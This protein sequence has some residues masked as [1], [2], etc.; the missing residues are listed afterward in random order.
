[1]CIT[2]D[3]KAF[4]VDFGRTMLMG[5]VAVLLPCMVFWLSGREP[6]KNGMG[7][8]PWEDGETISGDSRSVYIELNGR[9][10]D[11]EGFLLYMMTVDGAWMQEPEAL[12][13]YAIAVR[14]KLYAH[15]DWLD[16]KKD[17]RLSGN[18][19]AQGDLAATVSGSGKMILDNEEQI[20]DNRESIS[21]SRE[22]IENS[23]TQNQSDVKKDNI[24]SAASIG[25]SYD[26][27]GEMLLHLK[28]QDGN[29]TWIYGMNRI[30]EAI[31]KTRGMY[32]SY[33]EKK[34][35]EEKHNAEQSQEAAAT[36]YPGSLGADEM[37]QKKQESKDGM[38]TERQTEEPGKEMQTEEMQTEEIPA[39]KTMKPEQETSVDKDSRS[40]QRW[41]F[42]AAP[43]V[44]VLWH[45]NSAGK[46]R[47]YAGSSA[48]ETGISLYSPPLKS[49]DGKDETEA[50]RI[51]LI[52]YDRRTLAKLLWE[53]PGTEGILVQEAEDNLSDIL[54]NTVRDSVGYI[55]TIQI[56]SAV[57]TGETAAKLLKLPSGCFYWA[58]TEDGE[59]LRFVSYGTGSGYGISLRGA[60]NMAENG[61]GYRKILEYYYPV[62]SIETD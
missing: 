41:N 12:K 42:A 4:F 31:E 46:T 29:G 57:Y 50:D 5:L 28:E 37:N 48:D 35:E 7:R 30:K 44:D 54:Q 32:L 38:A 19:S 56:G 26:Q 55:E 1:M 36:E 16:R 43:A 51:Q 62:C 60:E 2:I 58:E 40:S 21:D 53:I 34:G 11:T 3:M 24:V 49:M 13:A 52:T 6:E 22:Q 59:A 14:S 9:Y 45:I 18:S 27:P 39:E 61:C 15:L 8:Y 23:K 20:V 17:E 25:V 33:T 47:M 10:L